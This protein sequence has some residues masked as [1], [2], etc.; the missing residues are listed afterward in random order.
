TATAAYG[1]YT[2][3]SDPNVKLSV[4]TNRSIL[5]YGSASMKDYKQPGMPQQ[6]YSVGLEYR[7][8]KFW[9]IGVNANYL[10]DNYLDISPILRTDNFLRNNSDPDGFPFA[11]ATEEETRKLLK[12][13][14]FDPIT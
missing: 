13:E 2:Y 3:D 14:K 7:D 12:Q 6:A 10:A 5:N 11:G 8:P 1:Q 9:W 4:D